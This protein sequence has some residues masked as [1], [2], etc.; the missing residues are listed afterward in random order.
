M[1]I[2]EREEVQAIGIESIFNKI[3]APQNSPNL[4]KRMP[5]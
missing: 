4:E 1:G 2:D 5:I 3:I